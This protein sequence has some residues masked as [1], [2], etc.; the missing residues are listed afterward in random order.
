MYACVCTAP[1]AMNNKW[2]D[3]DFVNNFCCFQHYFAALAA[4]ICVA[5]V[6]KN[7]KKAF[8]MLFIINKTDCISFKRGC[9]VQVENGKM[10][11][12]QLQPKK[13]VFAIY[14][15][16]KTFYLPSLLT[17]WSTL[18]LDVGVSYWW[19]NI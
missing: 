6:M 11:H 5:L 15:T 13:A 18:V 14:I 16:A 4:S 10:Y 12:H 2:R 8:Y 19:Q 9:V 17:K 3:F 7:S 1:E